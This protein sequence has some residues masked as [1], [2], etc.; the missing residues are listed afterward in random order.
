MDLGARVVATLAATFTLA[1]G[2]RGTGRRVARI[3]AGRETQALM[4]ESQRIEQALRSYEA[5]SRVV[6]GPYRGAAS[7]SREPD[8]TDR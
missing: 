7:P 6:G 8:C 4:A 1:V 2:V 5:S 3:K